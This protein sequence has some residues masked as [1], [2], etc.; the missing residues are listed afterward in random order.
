MC[1]CGN[2]VEEYRTVECRNNSPKCKSDKR[3][4]ER[5]I[6]PFQHVTNERFPYVNYNLEEKPIKIFN[7]RQ[8]RE[9]FSKR[10]FIDG[11]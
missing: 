6:V 2:V 1:P 5:V 4:M 8:E 7:R 3:K 9:E 11:R 10:G